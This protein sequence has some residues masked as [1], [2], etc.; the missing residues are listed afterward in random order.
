MDYRK[1]F[2]A[3]E[4]RKV[5]PDSIDPG[6]TGK[7]KSHKDARLEMSQHVE[8]MDKLQYLL[9]ADANQSLLMVMMIFPMNDDVPV[10]DRT[11]LYLTMSHED[12]AGY[13]RLTSICLLHAYR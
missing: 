7:H 2:I 6:Y 3:K 4:G 10:M 9:Y 1:K 11:H 13:T 8:R 12:C 5:R